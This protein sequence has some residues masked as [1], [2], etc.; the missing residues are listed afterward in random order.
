MK[1]SELQVFLRIDIAR[2]EVI[3]VINCNV[4]LVVLHCSCLK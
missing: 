2:K 1:G 3:D 4:I